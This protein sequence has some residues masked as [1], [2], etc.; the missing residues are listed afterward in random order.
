MGR[1]PAI[2]PHRCS[3][4]GRDTPGHDGKATGSPPK[5][6]SIRRIIL[7]RM[8]TR[9]AMT[10]EQRPLPFSAMRAGALVEDCVEIIADPIET[11]GEARPTDIARRLGVTHATAIRTIGRLKRD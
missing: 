6:F 10:E 8:R 3:A 5:S 11:E 7:I 9:P 1:V 2:H 4:D